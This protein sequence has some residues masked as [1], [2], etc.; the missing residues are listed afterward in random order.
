VF[1]RLSLVLFLAVIHAAAA[2][3][4][5]E[6]L[7]AA[8]RKATRATK[9]R[10]LDGIYSIRAPEFELLDLE[11]KRVNLQTEKNRQRVH[12]ATAVSAEESATLVSAQRLSPTTARSIVDYRAQYR[13]LDGVSPKPVLRVIEARC[14]DEW[15]RRDNEWLL[16]RTRV[17]SQRARSEKRQ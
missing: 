11:G 5:N 2:A 8:Y 9:L 16:T 10:Y 14:A 15:V 3:P 6:E 7:K 17:L 1:A 12:L 4:L 13:L